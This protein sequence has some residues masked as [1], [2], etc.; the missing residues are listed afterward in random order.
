MDWVLRALVTALAV[1]AVLDVAERFGRSIGG[2][3]AALPTIT[4]PAL[5]WVA[6]DRGTAFASD[7]AV[8]SVASCAMLAAFAAGYALAPRRGGIGVAIG[9]GL[10]GSAA[11]ALP[12]WYASASLAPALALSVAAWAITLATMPRRSTPILRPQRTARPRSFLMTAAL[13]GVLSAAAGLAGSAIGAFAAGVLASLPFI[14][15]AVTVV[16]H[17]THGPA[18]AAVFLRGYVDGLLGRAAFGALFAFLA[19]PAG[20]ALAMAIAFLGLGALSLATT[21]LLGPTRRS[22]RSRSGDALEGPR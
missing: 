3:C 11:L 20:T 12:T 21:R 4:A 19:V 7:V 15:G 2:F 17:A 8:A 18:A 9:C 13:A 1:A 14:S 5:A 16:E 10:F 6:F 22:S